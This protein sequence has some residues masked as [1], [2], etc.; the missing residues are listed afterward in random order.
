MQLAEK[1]AVDDLMGK[2]DE[3]E[4]CS[5]GIV[6]QN[7]VVAS[8]QHEPQPFAAADQEQRH[9][10]VFVSYFDNH[11]NAFPG[12]ARSADTVLDE[13]AHVDPSSSSS[14]EIGRASC[15]ERV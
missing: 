6:S 1:S 5:I 11:S 9:T 3:T 7:F 15:R 4:R 10:S 13:L 8:P 12:V 14:V 2:V